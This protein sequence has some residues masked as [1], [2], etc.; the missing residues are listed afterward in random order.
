MNVH[1]CITTSRKEIE[2]DPSGR[3][4]QFFIPQRK[5]FLKGPKENILNLRKRK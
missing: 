1:K 4:V 2:A 3:A 5:L